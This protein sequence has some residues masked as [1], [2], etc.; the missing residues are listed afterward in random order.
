MKQTDLSDM[1]DLKKQKLIQQLWLY[2]ACC[3]YGLCEYKQAREEVRQSGDSNPLQTRLLF[4]V[5]LKL[6]DE[7][8]IMTRLSNLRHPGRVEDSL[9]VAALQYLRLRFGDAIKI[10]RDILE[11]NLSLFAVHVYVSLCYYKLD[12]HELA[13]DILQDYVKKY[14]DSVTAVNLLAA[15]VYHLTDKGGPQAAATILLDLER[16]AAAGS[17]STTNGGASSAI[18]SNDLLRHNLSV[19]RNCPN[20]SQVLPPLVDII[21]E[22]RLNMAIYQLREGNIKEAFSLIKELNPV[23]VPEFL[24]KGVVLLALGQET[25]NSQLLG[26]AHELFKTVGMSPHA[27]DTI[28]GRQAMASCFFLY[29]KFAEVLVYLRSIAEYF[30]EEDTF[31]WNFGIALAGNHEYKEACAQLASIRDSSMRKDP[32]WL[33]WICRSYIR[34]GE[35][36]R[37]WELFEE[38]ETHSPDTL[39]I[40]RLI[41]DDFY[42]MG[43]FVWALR[44]FEILQSFEEAVG[45]RGAGPETELFEA[46]RGSAVGVFQQVIAGQAGEA[47]LQEAVRAL[48]STHNNP[49][50]EYILQ[51]IKKWADSHNMVRIDYN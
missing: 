16:R 14:P 44:S 47:E 36:E 8:E 34:S 28:Q 26:E 33:K 7:A 25:N 49:Q 45:G 11:D 12:Y 30:P 38:L 46:V 42:K 21:P 29:K 13:H 20:A 50:C 24:L 10:Y 2:K 5:A 32:V 17:S 41:A 3:S 40:L 19:F 39:E 35:P 22:A 9:C 6:N 23:I 43:Q 51:C 4:Q 15:C 1:D 37:A 18:Q 27:K 31:I 48:S